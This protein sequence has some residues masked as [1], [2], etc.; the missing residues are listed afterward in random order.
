[1]KNILTVAFFFFMFT[2]HSQE[3]INNYKYII[4]SDRFDFVKKTDMYQTSSL[5]KFLFKKNGFDAYLSSDKLPKEVYDNRCNTLF[6][7]VVNAS[8]VFV[9]KNHIEFR[10]CN[11]VVIYKSK[12][13]RSKEKEYKLAYHEA[14]R[15]AFTDVVISSYAYKE[16]ASS[17]TKSNVIVNSVE[18]KIPKKVIV[19]VK[20]IMQKDSNTIYAQPTSN[21][22]QLVDTSPKV[23]FTILQTSTEN[24]FVIKD[25]NGILFLRNS[26]W[27]AEYY[28]NG[29]LIQKELKIKF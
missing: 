26:K 13:G 29:Q 20:K 1:M 19:P 4:V 23:V 28:E 5:T 14:I 2:M 12:N 10:D 18:S 3:K 22:F 8:G 25:K 11:N 7:K 17:V 15:G 16:R 21:G 27:I 6:V 24:V 9:T